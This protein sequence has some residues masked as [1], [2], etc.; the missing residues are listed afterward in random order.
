MQHWGRGKPL[1][2]DLMQDTFH[3]IHIWYLDPTVPIYYH[4]CNVQ[5]ISTLYYS[6]VWRIG[7]RCF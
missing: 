2:H 6:D 1:V 7:I 4:A 3:H 5:I